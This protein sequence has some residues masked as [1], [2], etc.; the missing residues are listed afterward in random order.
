ML[1]QPEQVKVV[2]LLESDSSS[3]WESSLL[4][5]STISSDLARDQVQRVQAG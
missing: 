2:L 5:V 1:Q 4:K 3:S